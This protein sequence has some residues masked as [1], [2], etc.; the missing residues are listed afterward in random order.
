[1][2]SQSD[3]RTDEGDSLRATVNFV[4]EMLRTYK[5]VGTCISSLLFPVEAKEY[6]G[7][8]GLEEDVRDDGM[9]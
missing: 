8:L 3:L 7:L 2:D 1:M 4:R 6:H 5:S 9:C